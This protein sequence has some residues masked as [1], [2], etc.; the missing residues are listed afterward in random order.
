MR[1]LMKSKTKGKRM[2]NEIFPKPWQNWHG[3]EH[4][5]TFGCFQFSGGLE[6]QAKLKNYCQISGFAGE[7]L[8]ARNVMRQKKEDIQAGCEPME[9]SPLS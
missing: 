9:I 1:N 8:V 6:I 5:Y 2:S 3:V 7:K 4:P